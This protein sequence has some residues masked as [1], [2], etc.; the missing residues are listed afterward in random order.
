MRKKLNRNSILIIINL[1]LLGISVMPI[2]VPTG[3]D[4]GGEL[5]FILI[6]VILTLTFIPLVVKRFF[7]IRKAKFTNDESNNLQDNGQTT[8]L[9]LIKAP[10]ILGVI[11]VIFMLTDSESLGNLGFLLLLFALIS[12]VALTTEYIIEKRRK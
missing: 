9:K 5:L 6:S 4:A 2:I 7:I 12:F 10:I 3:G 1:V 11:G 8:K